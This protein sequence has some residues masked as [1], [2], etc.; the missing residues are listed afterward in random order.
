LPD[1]RTSL[2]VK[3]PPYRKYDDGSTGTIETFGRGRFRVPIELNKRQRGIYTLVVWLSKSH[4]EQ[5][6][7][8]THVC[9]RAE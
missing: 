5:P 6:F 8:A 9:I 3:L 2:Y 1:E 7:P 4:S